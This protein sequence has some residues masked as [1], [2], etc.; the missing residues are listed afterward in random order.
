MKSSDGAADPGRVTQG[1]WKIRE[2]AL[3]V[4]PRSALLLLLQRHPVHSGAETAAGASR[5]GLRRHTHTFSG[6]IPLFS[7]GGALAAKAGRTQG[8]RGRGCFTR[9]SWGRSLRSRG[10]R[11]ALEL[12]GHAR[13]HGGVPTSSKGLLVALAGVETVPGRGQRAAWARKLAFL[14]S[15]RLEVPRDL[16]LMLDLPENLAPAT[17]SPRCPS[18]PPTDAALSPHHRCSSV[19]PRLSQ[20]VMSPV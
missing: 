6:H 7:A 11:R 5:Q 1:R 13:V 18:T 4:R 17:L 14:S 10:G 20:K 12:G 15:W 16:E 19:F 9:R 8:A 2:T 3:T